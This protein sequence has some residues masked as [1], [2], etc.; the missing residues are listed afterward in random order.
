MPTYFGFSTGIDFKESLFQ[1]NDK[2]EY[3]LKNGMALQIIS[4]F[5][6]I[7]VMDKTFSVHLIDTVILHDD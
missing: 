4:P 6:N 7:E 5:S 2:N 1:I 3:I